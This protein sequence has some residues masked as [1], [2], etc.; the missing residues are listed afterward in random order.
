MK[1]PDRREP[2]LRQRK[3]QTNEGFKA[4]PVKS[5][6]FGV[7]CGLELRGGMAVAQNRFAIFLRQANSD[8]MAGSITYLAPV[9]NASG[10]I[11]GKK[12]RF[13][14][15]K[16]NWGNR[17]RGCSATGERDLKNHPMTQAEID[18]HTK[19]AAVAASV[20]A[21]LADPNQA[22]LDQMAFKEQTKYTTLR[23]YVW[24]LEWQAYA[25]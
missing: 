16:R 6:I 9:D 14:A 10:K 23:Q 1:S 5:L 19:F 7:L 15:V 4:A 8:D 21:R 2:S 17:R 20:S 24:N 11:F 13:V 18:H 25:G 3:P 12:Q 22:P